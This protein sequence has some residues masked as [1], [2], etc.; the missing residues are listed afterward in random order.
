MSP[1]DLAGLKARLEQI[2]GET[3]KDG[4]W[5]DHEA[6]Q[7]LLKEKKSLENKVGRYDKLAGELADVEVLIQLAEEEDDESLVEEIRES[8]ERFK[9]DA[10]ELRLSTLLTGE[11]DGNDAIVHIHA[12][13]GGTDAMD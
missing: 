11:Y 9:A 6:A 13:E 10:E 12:G 2:D 1:F 5:D 3:Q 4:F 7:K 8:Y